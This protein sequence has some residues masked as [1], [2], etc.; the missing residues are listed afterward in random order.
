M[1]KN[2]VLGIAG[3][4]SW[5]SGAFPALQAFAEK[6]RLERAEP[7][8]EVFTSPTAEDLARCEAMGRDLGTK[9]IARTQDR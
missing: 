1:P 8:V 4:Y 6:A 2:H 7:D 9:V 3:S 5:A